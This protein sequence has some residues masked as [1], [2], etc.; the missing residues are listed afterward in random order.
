MHK[1]M[2]HFTHNSED[3]RELIIDCWRFLIRSYWD[4]DCSDKVIMKK[5][6]KIEYRHEEE[7]FEEIKIHLPNSQIPTG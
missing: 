1:I 4:F 7:N 2:D 3:L 5:L 6:S